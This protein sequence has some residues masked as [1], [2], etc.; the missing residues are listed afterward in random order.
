MLSS[1]CIG[2]WALPQ[3]SWLVNWNAFI[4]RHHWFGHNVV[5]CDFSRFIYY[6]PYDDSSPEPGIGVKCV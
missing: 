1:T 3:P 6:P 4:G 5:C 2:F